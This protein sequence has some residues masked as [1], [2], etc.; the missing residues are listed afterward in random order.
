MAV[1][2]KF[3]EL[4]L[5]NG[6]HVSCKIEV[7]DKIYYDDRILYF[8]LSDVT[9]PDWFTIGTT[10][11]NEFSFK[12]IHYEKPELQTTVKPFI[13][14]DGKEWFCL[15]IFYVSRR[16]V[17]GKYATFVCYD[18][19]NSLGVPLSDEITDEEFSNTDT[20][21]NAV[22]KQVGVKFSGNC[23][24]H[25]AFKPKSDTTV[26]NVIGYIAALN[27]AC[28]KIDKSGELVFK[29]YKQ[30][31]S[32]ETQRLSVNNC[33]HVN[34][35]ITRAFIGGIRV[36][37]GTEMLHYGE[38]SG[39][40]VVDITNPFMTQ[41][42]LNS[43]GKQLKPFRFY[44]A[45]IK[46][47]GLPFLETGEFI[48]LENKNGSLTPLVISEIKYHYDGAF[49]AELFSKNKYVS[50]PPVGKQAFESE[51]SKLWEFVLENHPQ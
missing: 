20:L 24:K 14:F 29:E 9:H 27:C 8:N 42:V 35:N 43:L 39:P 15:G 13:S 23:A 7:G 25:T 40:S 51:I 31:P 50:D 32:E 12:V 17:R 47:Q 3:K 2:E 11:S 49:T 26:R 4:A 1:S 6:R 19:M 48:Q 18:K 36:N 5:A 37:T 10:C 33:F 34:R 38:S 46:M 21:L 22:C 30:A 28:A 16:Y 44:G 41:S 45:E